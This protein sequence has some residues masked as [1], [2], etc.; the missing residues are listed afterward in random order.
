MVANLVHVL[1]WKY[2]A[3]CAVDHPGPQAEKLALTLCLTPGFLFSLQSL[4][5]MKKFF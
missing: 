5:E 2:L 1:P 4:R 3:S